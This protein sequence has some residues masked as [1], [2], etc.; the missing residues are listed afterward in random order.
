MD[1]DVELLPGGGGEPQEADLEAVL[2]YVLVLGPHY[3]GQLLQIT[4]LKSRNPGKKVKY[5]LKM[6]CDK[7]LRFSR[8]LN[9]GMS[10]WTGASYFTMNSIT[11]VTATVNCL[12]YNLQ[13]TVI[14]GVALEAWGILKY[15]L[16][17]QMEA[18]K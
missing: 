18:L 12:N 10:N 2:H 14:E 8:D 9:V 15:F 13:S 5:S 17:C 11:S 1:R 3:L 7:L 4:K 6:V 16:Q